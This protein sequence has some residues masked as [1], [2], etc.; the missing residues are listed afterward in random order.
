MPSGSSS[1]SSS[2]TH[3]PA[4]GDAAGVLLCLHG[5]GVDG[6]DLAPLAIELGL[7]GWHVVF[8]HAPLDW[9]G[10]GRAW[11]LPGPGKDEGIR[12]AS[13][14]IR[15][16]IVALE[17]AGAA[18]RRIAV[19]GFSQ[20]S[21]VGMHAALRHERR[22]G[23]ALGLSGYL[24]APEAIAAEASAANA[25]LP[26]LIAHGTHDDLLPAAGARAA[27]EALRACGYP[28]EYI[29]YDMGHEIC[30]EELLALR[31]FLL[32][33]VPAGGAGEAGGAGS[34]Q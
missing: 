16:E 23:A 3:G 17:S 2:I 29:E 25:D 32:R 12:V 28:V 13:E 14:A 8:P 26:L 10:G 1:P 20:G 22:L 15:A 21:V 34:E 7:D 9:P 6:H 4:P 27:A 11:Y 33:A 19:L 30:Y 18:S 5:R 24:Y 31:G